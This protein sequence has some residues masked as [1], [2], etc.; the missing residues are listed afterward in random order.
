MDDANTAGENKTGMCF[1]PKEAAVMTV[2]AKNNDCVQPGRE[3]AKAVVYYRC[4]RFGEARLP[5][6]PHTTKPTV[7]FTLL[8]ILVTG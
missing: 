4:R 1:S 3:Q 8:C 5:A 2:K 7:G 6:I